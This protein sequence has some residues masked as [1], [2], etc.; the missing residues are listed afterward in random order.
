VNYRYKL[1]LVI[2][3]FNIIICDSSLKKIDANIK[4]NNTELNKIITEI[5]KL[6]KEIS[7]KIEEEENNQEIINKL[8]S[9]IELTEQLIKSLNKEENYLSN[10]IYKTEQNIK[11]KEQ[12]LNVL[13]NQ[14]KNRLKYLYK[15]GK[16]GILSDMVSSQNW[17]NLIYRTKYLEVLNQSEEK[18]KKRINESLE[19]LKLE[20]KALKKEK[21]RKTY[22]LNEKDKEFIKLEKDKKKKEKYISNIKNQKKK[23]TSNLQIKK[24]AMK[25]IE[26]II[27]KLYNDKEELRKR[28]E[29]LIKLRSQQN[30]STSDN[31]VKMKGRL[32]W[33]VSGEI[34]GKFGIKTNPELNTQFENIGIDIKTKSSESVLSVLDGMVLSITLI[35]GYGKV[36]IIDHGHGYYTVYSNVDNI[37]VNENDY[38]PSLYKIGT[39]AKNNSS[40]YNKDYIFHFQVWGNK[41]K[42]NPQEWLKKK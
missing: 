30:K 21:E 39:V 1:S 11:I 25:Q 6:E 20:K 4:K 14:L 27:S 29:E 34:I 36:I 31:F 7:N 32:P 2:L 22:L 19:N 9:K 5:K 17:S 28:E 26:K 24:V 38:I 10:L 23:L 35:T 8:N 16:S 15:Y 3:L 42:L 13:K 12:E 40:Q 37:N 33:P 18:I 41:K